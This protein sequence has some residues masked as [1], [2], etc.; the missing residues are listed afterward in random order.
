MVEH[1]REYTA[2]LVVMDSARV[3]IIKP[4]MCVPYSKFEY[5]ALCI[6][7]GRTGE[8]VDELAAAEPDPLSWV[9]AKTLSRFSQWP[10]ILAETS[11]HSFVEGSS[12]ESALSDS[13]IG[14]RSLAAVP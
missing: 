6:C 1:S 4:D 5:V 10:M 8:Y 3:L 12:G 7:T 9:I 14:T 13:R 2:N 11:S